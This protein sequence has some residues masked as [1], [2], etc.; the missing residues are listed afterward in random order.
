MLR[1]L[2]DTLYAKF[3]TST[4][5]VTILSCITMILFWILIGFLGSLLIGLF[6]KLLRNKKKTRSARAKTITKLIIRLIQI[7]FWFYI[8]VMILHEIGFDIIP[9]IASAGV[10]ALGIGLGAQSLFTDWIA[11]IFLLSENMIN[12]GNVVDIDG[13]KGTIINITFRNIHIKN[14]KNE[15]RVISNGTIKSFTNYSLYDSVS[16]IELALAYP[17]DLSVFDKE[18]FELLLESFYNNHSDI[19]ITPI[20]V[21]KITDIN[22]NRIKVKF[23]FVGKTESFYQ[24][25]RQLRE[26][27]I[28]Y[29]IDNN[30]VLAESVL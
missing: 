24:V 21:L 3:I 23:N 10:V 11:G 6:I 27:L 20:D 13:F 18:E 22:L 7:V 17:A 26:L 12:V 1:T 28:K 4:D 30:L 14:W 5:V 2:L 9:V 8:V 19:M 15:V 29:C 16:S 25:E